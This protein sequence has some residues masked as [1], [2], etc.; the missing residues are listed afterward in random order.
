MVNLAASL[1]AAATLVV[2]S[3]AGGATS[4]GAEESF[5]FTG[6]G[7]GHGVGL[8]QY[9]ACGMASGGNNYA[10]I[11]AHYYTGTQLG[12]VT[13]PTNLRVLLAESN[14]F[15]LSVPA[16][17]MISNVGTISSNQT[18]TV[19]RSGGNVTLTGGVSGTV[20]LPLTVVQNGAMTI[21]P[22][23][24]RFDRGHLVIRASDGDPTKLR[25]IIDG[26]STRDYLLGLGEMP[27]S[28]PAEALKTQ[29]T[30][31][32]TV[33]V[34]KAASGAGS[35]HDLKGYLDGAYIGYEVYAHAGPTYW[36]KWV[37]AIDDTTGQVVT[38][39][40]NPITSAVYSSSS[41]GRTENSEN[42]WS[43]TVPYLK[44]IDDP[45]DSG[46]N[47]P[48]NHWAVSFTSSQLGAKLRIPAVQSINVGG[49]V[50]PSGRTDK[51]T[52][53]FT[54]VSGAKHNFTGAQLRWAL[55]LYSTKFTI[56]GAT[57]TPPPEPNR[58]PSGTLGLLRAHEG[59]KIL[60]AGR[61]SDPDG[62]PRMFVADEANGRTHWHVF[63]S[64]N[65]NF[66]A[67]FPVEPGKHTTCVAVLNTPSGPA[68]IL[69]CGTTV[70]K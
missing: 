30:A 22:P 45:T 47:N 65:G 67:A 39:G 27:A 32:R 68:T 57:Q 64:A 38:H 41:G 4:A 14:T 63:N 2:A 35:D 5:T 40:G 60:V 9:G 33:A 48:R 10:Q 25:A 50:A 53:T 15:T 28:W 54:D 12:G 6:G 46:C 42:V 18:V 11:L 43:A 56:S 66:M 13:E 62:T 44:G 17:S 36:P 8:S 19:Q 16:G 58:P 26:L 55:G 7:W 49:N 23:G 29:A 37:A 52:I 70:V 24:D 31:A 20:P 3:F 59:R 69:G 51:A 61:A 1:L 34:V 21:S